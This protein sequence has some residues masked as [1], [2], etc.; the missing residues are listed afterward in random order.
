MSAAN[1]RV[2]P[3]VRTACRP[4]TAQR[5]TEDRIFLTANAVVLLD[6]ASQPEPGARDG[7]WYA[8]V[9]GSEVQQRLAVEPLYDLDAVVFDAISSV[10]SR[11]GLQPRRSPSATVSIARWTDDCVDVFLLGDSPVIALTK[12]GEII[13][14]RDDRLKKVAPA[15]RRELALAGGFGFADR[16]RWRGLV[17]AER[18][19]RNRPD[20]YW[21]A[22]AVPAAARHA[23]HAHWPRTDLET[24][25]LM[26]DGVSAAVD[27]YRQPPDWNSALNMVQRDPEQLIDLVHATEVAD[28]DGRRWPRSKLHDD[29]ALAV[30]GFSRQTP[31]G[32]Q[33]IGNPPAFC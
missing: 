12:S 8:D 17:E 3:R 6:G 28:P 10:T 16:A 32:G 24:V 5:P 18:A 1:A 2:E 33:L 27:R 13:H 4:G 30:V 11:F 20:G 14:V 19:A 21:I 25:L 29:K 15:Q 9:L 22:E 26:S 31:N 23:R 7:G